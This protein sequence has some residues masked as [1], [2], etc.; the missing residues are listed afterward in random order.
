MI[1]DTR[2]GQPLV[3]ASEGGVDLLVHECFPPPEVMAKAMDA[4]V[5]RAAMILNLSHTIPAAAGTVFSHVK[6][7]MAGLTHTLISPPVVPA[8]FD[9][10]RTTYEGPVVQIQDL[11]VF[12]ITEASVV[13][14]QAQVNPQPPIVVGQP[15]LSPTVDEPPEVPEWWAE[16]LLIPAGD[17]GG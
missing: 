7:R 17:T 12:N 16:A 9:S 5:E 11:T 2:P 6:P 15:T 10:L 4:P 3:R 14:R 1:G 13:V 8:M